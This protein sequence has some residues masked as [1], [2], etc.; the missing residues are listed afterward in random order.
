MAESHPAISDE[1]PAVGQRIR[2]LRRAQKLRASHLA[3]EL[4]VSRTALHKWECGAS[5]PRPAAMRALAGRLG[6]TPEF[7][8]SG[9]SDGR[10]TM[11]DASVA[12]ILDR[13]RRA[14]ASASGLPVEAVILRMEVL[15]AA[16]VAAAKG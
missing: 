14:L 16:Y 12:P 8:R 5:L 7:L 9:S 13:A 11:A 3:A 6:V 2:D 10:G 15:P 1:M 4:G